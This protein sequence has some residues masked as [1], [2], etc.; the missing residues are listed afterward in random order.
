MAEVC[1]MLCSE[2]VYVLSIQ[3]VGGMGR[4]LSQVYE[5]QGVIR[6]GAKNSEH[7]FPRWEGQV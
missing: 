2:L 3:W 4:L 7:N 5:I 1:R 6:L